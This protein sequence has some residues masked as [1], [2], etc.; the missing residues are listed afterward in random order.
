LQEAS[1]QVKKKIKQKGVANARVTD[2][3]RDNKR[4]RRKEDS[5]IRSFE[6][7]KAEGAAALGTGGGWFWPYSQQPGKGGHADSEGAVN[8][9]MAKGGS[10]IGKPWEDE[11]LGNCKGENQGKAG[12]TGQKLSSF[13]DRRGAVSFDADGVASAEGGRECGTKKSDRAASEGRAGG[14][15]ENLLRGESIQIE[16]LGSAFVQLLTKLKN[17]SDRTDGGG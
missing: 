13:K 14:E 12:S 2:W 9:Q 10:S 17:A 11:Q 3:G 8:L 4:R 1:K 15:T 5:K 7:A 16:P 6:G